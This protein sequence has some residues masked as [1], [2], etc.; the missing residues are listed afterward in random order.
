MKQLLYE[1]NKRKIHLE[2]VLNYIE[3]AL[4]K[5]PQGNLRISRM[6]GI[7]RYYH[8]TR[9][10]DTKGKYIKKKDIELAKG[11]AQRDYLLQLRRRAHAEIN[12]VTNHI[13]LLKKENIESVYSS[14]NTYRQELVTPVIFT[15]EMYIRQWE[16]EQFVSNPFHPEEK[17]YPTKKE[18]FV[19]S[20]SEVMIADMYY[21]LNIPYRYEAELHLSNG[22]IK[23]PDFT[24]L[25]VNRREVIYH[26][27]LGLLDDADYRKAN[28]LKLNEYQKNG[29]YLGKNLIIT[30]EAEGVYLNILELKKMCRELFFKI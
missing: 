27:H 26:E 8:M 6:Q 17:V 19:R 16:Q 12:M 30:Y 9:V 23:F 14:L 1:L 24:L 25:N 21:E 13:D 18:E 11:L 20:K 22:K 28:L 10:G 29:I 3:E 4:T 15:D 5:V 7:P 2:K